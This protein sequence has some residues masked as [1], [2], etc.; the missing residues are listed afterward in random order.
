MC[1]IWI[2]PMLRKIKTIV[3]ISIT[4]NRLGVLTWANQPQIWTTWLG[5]MVSEIGR[6]TPVGRTERANGYAGRQSYSLIIYDLSLVTCRRVNGYAQEARIST[7]NLFWHF[8]YRWL[9]VSG[10]RRP[11]QTDE[12]C[13]KTATGSVKIKVHW[14]VSLYRQWFVVFRDTSSLNAVRISV[15]VC[16]SSW[17]GSGA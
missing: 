12:N 8:E 15:V 14:S 6:Q 7:T 3:S 13:R 16:L 11:K 10:K 17:D 2:G 9:G 5:R 4:K 1:M